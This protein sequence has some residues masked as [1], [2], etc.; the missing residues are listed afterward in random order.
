MKKAKENISLFIAV[1]IALVLLVTADHYGLPNKWQ[2]AIF[3]TIVPFWAVVALYP[4]R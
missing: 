3:G 1:V 4:L 2:T